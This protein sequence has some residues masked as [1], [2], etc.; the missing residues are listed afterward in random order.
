MDAKGSQL[1]G[2]R[3]L[4]RQPLIKAK[5]YPGRFPRGMMRAI[6]W[7]SDDR[8]LA[9]GHIPLQRVKWRNTIPCT[10]IIDPAVHTVWR[11]DLYRNNKDDKTLMRKLWGLL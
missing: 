10:P 7:A 1:R 9:R 5:T 2:R 4:V 11:A 8:M 6:N 3:S